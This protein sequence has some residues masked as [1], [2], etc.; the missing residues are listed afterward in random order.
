MPDPGLPGVGPPGSGLPGQDSSDPGPSTPSSPGPGPSPA[1]ASGA[2]L[3]LVL[4]VD[5]SA[6]V[7]F[8]EFN[9]IAGGLGAALRDPDVAA[10]LTGG[11]RGASLCALLLFSGVDAQE[12]VVDWVRIADAAAAL[13]FAERVEGV[14]RIVAAGLT[15]IGSALDAAAGLLARMPSP[16][17]RHVVD[18]AGDG[19]S[20]A[21]P[22]PAEARDRLVA[23]GATINGLCVLHE[24]PDLVATFEREVIG[25]PGA[26]AQP[27]ADYAGFAEAMR[28]KLLREAVVA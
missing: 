19:A 4:A 14:P 15:A 24:E 20:N 1:A 28:R 8:D 26:F 10:A 11:P 7:T 13:A 6:S 21:G 5:A 27:C 25:G 2:D 3:A 23:A 9:L 17:T 16:A 22:S 12:V 18:V